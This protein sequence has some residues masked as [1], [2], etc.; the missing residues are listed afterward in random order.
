MKLVAEGGIAEVGA[1]C[2]GCRERVDVR[3]EFMGRMNLDEQMEGIL[4]MARA[5]EVCK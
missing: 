2:E 4:I 5:T 3:F 1:C